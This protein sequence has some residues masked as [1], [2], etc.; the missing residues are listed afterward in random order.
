MK[1]NGSNLLSISRNGAATTASVASASPGLNAGFFHI[2]GDP[3]VAGNTWP[4]YVAEIITYNSFLSTVE[5]QLVEG[6]L[7]DRWGLRS[8]FL[9]TF[10]PLFP[11]T[12]PFYRSPPISRLFTPVDVIGC[13]VWFDAADKSTITGSNITAWRSKGELAVTGVTGSGTLVSGLCNINGLNA[14]SIPLNA[15]LTCSTPVITTGNARSVYTVHYAN[16]STGQINFFGLP[17]L[18]D[19][20]NYGHRQFVSASM[21]SVGIEAYASV[22]SGVY[23]SPALISFG[24]PVMTVLF[25]S[26][27]AANSNVITV[28]GTAQTRTSSTVASGYSNQA[29]TYSLG[30]PSNNGVAYVLGEYVLCVTELSPLQRQQMEGY[31]AWKWKLYGNL[32]STHP[33]KSFPPYT[34]SFSPM[35][36][37]N[38]L[39]WLDAADSSTVDV[40]GGGVSRWSDKSGNARHATQAT[41]TRR[42]TLQTNQQ[43]GLPAIKWDGVDDNL[44]G[45]IPYTTTTTTLFVVYNVTTATGDQ[46]VFDIN[47]N[48]YGNF[49]SPQSSSS[50]DVILWLGGG[51]RYTNLAP[52]TGWRMYCAQYSV[53]TSAVWRNGT[54]VAMTTTGTPSTTATG[55]AY[56]LGN[57]ATGANSGQ[58]S[59]HIGELILYSSAVTITLFQRQQ[60][61]GYLANKWGLRS[62][63]P[64]THLYKT[65]T[66]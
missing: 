30:T 11:T 55:T 34:T 15:R 2:G 26:G 43:N 46:R 64:T 17:T 37:S 56:T 62:A 29:K 44:T 10:P 65:A 18:N 12:H 51:G 13:S 1:Y 50:A 32:P 38:M 28:N 59:G 22:S 41:S 33:F 27:L 6:Y 48:N 61:E 31:L 39:L 7:G 23:A 40:I 54:S 19:G 3:Y 49:G 4:G 60:I 14:V 47:G 63:L 8:N 16:A 58:F 66:P 5:T 52:S 9:T 45:S 57:I 42:P 36:T 53:G 20:V 24:T 25:H 35:H 21:T